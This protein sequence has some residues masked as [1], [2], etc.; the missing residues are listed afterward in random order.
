MLCPCLSLR[1]H[2]EP[3]RA[4]FADGG[5]RCLRPGRFCGEGSAVAFVA[6]AFQA[7]AFCFVGRSFRGDIIRPQFFA[8]YLAAAGL[9]GGR[10]VGRAEKTMTAGKGRVLSERIGLNA[11]KKR[12]TGKD[13]Q[14]TIEGEEKANFERSHF[15]AAK[16]RILIKKEGYNVPRNAHLP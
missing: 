9:R 15:A 14:C 7:V 2:P 13:H 10:L 11:P 5:A 1:C 16:S 6:A 8:P 12:E 3:R 4:I